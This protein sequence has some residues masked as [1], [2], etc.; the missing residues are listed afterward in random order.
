MLN[1]ESKGKGD[2]TECVRLAQAGDHAALNF[3]CTS[4]SPLVH[5]IAT[6]YRGSRADYE[7]LVQCGFE[8]LLTAIRVFDPSVGV[9]FGH[10]VKVRV[11][12]G[13]ASWLRKENAHKS[14]VQYEDPAPGVAGLSIWG[15]IADPRSCEFYEISEWQDSFA[16]LS[17]REM[18]AIEKI[19]IAGLTTRELAEQEGVSRET[20]KTWHRRAIMKVRQSASAWVR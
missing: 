9:Y 13:V 17:P 18:L 15:A 4:Y 6:R 20:A 5:A 8:H 12:F 3:L 11:R 10:F 14:R 2:M 16:S 7:D 19:V 1:M